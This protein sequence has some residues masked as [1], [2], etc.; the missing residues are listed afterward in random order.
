LALFLAASAAARRRMSVNV[1]GGQFSTAFG[2]V[3]GSNNGA[4]GCPSQLSCATLNY[5]INFK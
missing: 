5:C 4:D 1:G 3:D 2:G